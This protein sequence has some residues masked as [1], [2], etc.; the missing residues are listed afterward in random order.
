MSVANEGRLLSPDVVLLQRP[1]LSHK[2]DCSSLDRLLFAGT[3]RDKQRYTVRALY[4]SSVSQCLLSTVSHSLIQQRENIHCA[5][6][7]VEDLHEN[8]VRLVDNQ[9]V[10]HNPSLKT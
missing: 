4:R 5:W 2:V 8:S 9:S 10:D 6:S 1:L 7:I 3:Q